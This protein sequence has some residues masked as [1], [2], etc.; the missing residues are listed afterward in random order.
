MTTGRQ[1]ITAALRKLNAVSANTPPT[2]EDVQVAQEALEHL[3]ESK[4]ND[5]LNIHQ[6]TPYVFPTKSGQYIYTLGPGG[7]WDTER[8]MRVEKTRLLLNPRFDQTS[9]AVATVDV[10]PLLANKA[11]VN[12]EGTVSIPLDLIADEDYASIMARGVQNALPQVCLDNGGFPLRQLYFW[13]IPTENSKAVELWL[14]EPLQIP[15]LDTEL[16]LP[17]GYERY[18]TYALAA[19][20]CDEFGKK[21]TGE[22]IQSLQEAESAIRSLN[23]V[24][25]LQKPSDALRAL[26]SASTSWNI[27]D[28]YAGS[29][30]TGNKIY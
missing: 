8:P 23:Q 19:E 7:D 26:N 22:I 28:M 14:W 4:S 3:I 27:L 30:L 11:A 25:F 6:I 10:E 20:L 24:T 1:L 2:A 16:N 5:L 9:Q 15:D 29:W 18:L 17:P 13:P 21:L 12:G